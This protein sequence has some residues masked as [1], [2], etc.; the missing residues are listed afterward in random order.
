MNA[1]VFTRHNTLLAE[2]T[3]VFV[4]SYHTICA[5]HK[6]V[7]GTYAYAELLL[8]LSTDKWVK[9][10]PAFVSVNPYGRLKVKEIIPVE[11]HTCKFTQPASCALFENRRNK[12]HWFNYKHQHLNKKIAL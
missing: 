6:R 3:G 8:T 10:K 1:L 4:P 9:R 2:N 12:F 7:C 11:I 5:A